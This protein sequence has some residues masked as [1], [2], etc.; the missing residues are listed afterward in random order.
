MEN[1]TTYQWSM[2]LI[3]LIDK[4]VVGRAMEINKNVGLVN[5]KVSETL[6]KS[7]ES[8]KMSPTFP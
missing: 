2:I 7:T 6:Y 1:R 3:L 4:A 8:M 5:V